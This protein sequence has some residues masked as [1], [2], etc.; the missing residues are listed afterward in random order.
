MRSLRGRRDRHRN[1]SGLALNKTIDTGN[2]SG[3]AID[4]DSIDCE[5]RNRACRLNTHRDRNKMRAIHFRLSPA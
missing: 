2:N 3:I 4:C 5:T 1:C